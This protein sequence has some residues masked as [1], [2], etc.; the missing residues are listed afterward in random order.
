MNRLQISLR[1]SN[2]NNTTQL[3]HSLPRDCVIGIYWQHGE[4]IKTNGLELKQ[5]T[6]SWELVQWIAV[7]MATSSIDPFIQSHQSQGLKINFASGFRPSL[8]IRCVRFNELGV[9]SVRIQGRR[10]WIK[11]NWSKIETKS[12][13]LF[14]RIW[15]EAKLFFVGLK[16]FCRPVRKSIWFLLYVQH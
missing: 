14:F 3:G 13:T 9:V 8:I 1:G 16:F 11:N 7:Y 2:N 6:K 15:P 5:N 4:V 12:P 10:I